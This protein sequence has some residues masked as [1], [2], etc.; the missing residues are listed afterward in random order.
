METFNYIYTTALENP[1]T[2]PLI[3]GVPALCLSVGFVGIVY[4]LLADDL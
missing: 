4:T 1:H 3:F 2:W